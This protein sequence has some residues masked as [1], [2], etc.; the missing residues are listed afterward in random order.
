MGGRGQNTRRPR[1]EGISPCEALLGLSEAVDELWKGRRPRA[2][3]ARGAGRAAAGWKAAPVPATPQ[4]PC[5]RKRP[6]PETVPNAQA[7]GASALGTPAAACSVSCTQRST[8]RAVSLGLHARGRELH[9]RGCAAAQSPGAADAAG[10]RRRRWRLRSTTHVASLVWPSA[11]HRGAS[12]RTWSARSSCG[13]A[14]VA[15]TLAHGAA[16]PSTRCRPAA[17]PRQITFRSASSFRAGAHSG[18]G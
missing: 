9:A 1:F 10:R 12:L 2:S 6:P 4:Q 11:A 8:A 7:S 15:A 16:P 3:S 13:R 5:G 18:N 14:R 17:C